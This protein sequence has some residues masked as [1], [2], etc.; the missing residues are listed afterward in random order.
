MRW[1][2][3]WPPQPTTMN[4]NLIVFYGRSVLVFLTCLVIAPNTV[5]GWVWECLRC[6]FRCH[7]KMQCVVLTSPQSFCSANGHRG[8]WGFLRKSKSC[9]VGF[10]VVLFCWWLRLEGTKRIAAPSVL[11]WNCEHLCLRLCVRW[12]HCPPLLAQY[13]AGNGLPVG[14]FPCGFENHGTKEYP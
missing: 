6:C 4:G 1:E 8:Q 9:Q 12:F 14:G 2:G 11:S 10:V 5:S 13:P 7:I 3:V